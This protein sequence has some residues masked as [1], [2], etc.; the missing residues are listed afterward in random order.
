M[1]VV[2]GLTCVFLML[3]MAG[4]LIKNSFRRLFIFPCGGGGFFI[5]LTLLL[6]FFTVYRVDEDADFGKQIARFFGMGKKKDEAQ[7][8]KDDGK[9]KKKK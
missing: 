1:T 5:I 9:G 4:K 3:T 8:Q 2:R 7:S 6:L